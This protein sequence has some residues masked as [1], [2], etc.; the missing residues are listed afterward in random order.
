V[1]KGSLK[2]AGQDILISYLA[3][4]D[5]LPR[6][7]ENEAD[8][9]SEVRTVFEQTE[10]DR[11]SRV[12]AIELVI[13]SLEYR[14]VLEINQALMAERPSMRNLR[15][16]AEFS[17]TGILYYLALM[18]RNLGNWNLYDLARDHMR[19]CFAGRGSKLF[20]DFLSEGDRQ[21]IASMF[22]SVSGHKKEVRSIVFSEEPKE[23]V[24]HGLLLRD[25]R[26]DLT[27]PEAL[28]EP[29]I[30]EVLLADGEER[31]PDSVYTDLATQRSWRCEQL[32]TLRHMID[33]YERTMERRVPFDKTM[34]LDVA[35]RVA[36]QLSPIQTRAIE[37]SGHKARLGR[38]PQGAVTGQPLFILAL[39]ETVRQFIEK[40]RAIERL[41]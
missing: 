5:L 23:E 21:R 13:N 41:T 34:E 26:H 39:K 6:L 15:M 31:P 29:I 28:L 18:T 19:I 12:N 17:L 11:K 2:F 37:D 27:I 1:W 16:I 40:D 33:L 38:L 4:S 7:L 32:P 14:N 25:K 24:A 35:D 3:S 36:A 10:R 30:G 9:G 20:Q 22:Q 8:V